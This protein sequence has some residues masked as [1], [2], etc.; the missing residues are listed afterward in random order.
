[1]E[2]IEKETDDILDRLLPQQCYDLG[3]CGKRDCCLHCLDPCISCCGRTTCSH[4][5]TDL[6]LIVINKLDN[7][8]IDVSLERRIL[9][10]ETQEG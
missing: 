8:G 3:V 1:M 2:G 6:F 10:R 7:K 4:W 5:K 9:E